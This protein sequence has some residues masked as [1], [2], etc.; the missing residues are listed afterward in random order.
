MATCPG[1]AG[2][3]R[4]YGR[5]GKYERDVTLGVAWVLHADGYE[6]AVDHRAA[7]Y[8]GPRYLFGGRPM[9]GV[10][11]LMRRRLIVVRVTQGGVTAL[12]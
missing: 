5:P 10:T 3:R 4:G 2:R 9:P 7:R 12:P 11:V 8:L 1:G 6:P